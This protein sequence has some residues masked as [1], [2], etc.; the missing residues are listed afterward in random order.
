MNI[1]DAKSDRDLLE[2]E[3]L[4]NVAKVA[5]STLN[6]RE[7]LD[8]IVDI[9]AESLRKDVCSIYL[10]KSGGIICLEATKGLNKEA[11]GR[12]CVSSGEG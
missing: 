1:E 10:L 4:I 9:I 6:L 7:I 12:A 3:I 5:N 11:I 8:T 2:T